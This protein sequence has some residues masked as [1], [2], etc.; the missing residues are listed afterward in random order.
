MFLTQK[1]NLVLVKLLFK[2]KNNIQ[3]LIKILN[4]FKNNNNNKR[5]YINLVKI[6]NLY[7]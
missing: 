7:K 2:I 4:K 5:K 6:F 1:K 3:I